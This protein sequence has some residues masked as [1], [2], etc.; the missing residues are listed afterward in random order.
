MCEQ[1]FG[2]RVQEYGLREV[3][4]RIPDHPALAGLDEDLLKNWRGEATN[5]APRL[6]YEERPYPLIFPTIV[7][8]GVVV[9]RP[10][11]CGNRGNVASALIEKPACGDFMSLVDGGYSL[12]YSPLMEYRE[13]KGV[14]LFCQ[15]DVTGRTERDPAADRLARNILAY[16]HAFKPTARRSLVYAGDPA[17]LKHLQSA[18]F[19]VEPYV[20]G[21][22]TGD[23]VLVVSSGG[24]AALAPDK[25]AIAAWLGQDGRMIALGLDADEANT[26]MPIAVSM[27]SSEHIGSFFDHPPWNS[28]FAGIGPA[29][30]HNREPRNFS[31]IT[32]KANILGDGVLGF[33]DN[34]RV[35]FCQMVPW[36]F[37]TKQQNTRRTFRRT[38]ALLTRVL[39][40]LGVQ[41]QTSLLE[42]FSKPVTSIA[43]QSPEKPR[44]NA[45]YLD[46]L[47]EWD[48]PYR[49]F[50]W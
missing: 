26:F 33:A 35:I 34:G 50:G 2:F 36:Q 44:M 29:D 17:G 23:R 25:A 1:R 10:W 11:R 5:T 13:G 42:R 18:G 39:G 4:R 40:N 16:V 38:S 15:M 49:F 22:L 32:G 31:L 3:F 21:A 47:E 45:F 41:S 27:K 9:T 30:V 20:K 48:D 24:G 43:G 7:N 8:A 14:V 19:A 28:P 46:T 37:S 12:Q 6:T